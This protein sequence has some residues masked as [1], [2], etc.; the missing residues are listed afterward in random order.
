MAA[1][2]VSSSKPLR[3]LALSL[4][5]LRAGDGRAIAARSASLRRHY[6]VAVS[7]IFGAIARRDASGELSSRR[8]EQRAAMTGFQQASIG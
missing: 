4:I 1:F 7:A 6:G 2:R 5:T 3:L 8:E